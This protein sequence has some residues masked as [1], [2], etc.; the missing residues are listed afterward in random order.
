MNGVLF[1]ASLLISSYFHPKKLQLQSQVGESGKNEKKHL[2]VIA[3]LKLDNESLLSSK[4]TKE[5]EIVVVRS[6]VNNYEYHLY[7]CVLPMLFF[8]QMDENI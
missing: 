6:C 8:L 7:F 3:Q 5:S 4:S 2:A 1:D